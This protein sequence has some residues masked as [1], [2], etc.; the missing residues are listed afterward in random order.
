MDYE[1]LR[2]FQRMEKNSSSLSDLSNDFYERLAQ[3]IRDKTA[4]YEETKSVS[5]LRELE[6]IKK[7]ALD[8]FERR[9]QKIMLKAL[10]G[11]RINDF[12]DSNFPAFEKELFEQI[13]ESLNNKKKEFESIINGEITLKEKEKIVDEKIKGIGKIVLV[14]VLKSMPKFIGSHMQELGP[15][16]ENEIVKLPEEDAKMLAEKG[17]AEII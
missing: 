17:F 11:V 2:K 12:S 1:E 10:H 9:E 16:E 6:N 15:F 4:E 5:V 13:I 3:L 7:I 8:L 14:R